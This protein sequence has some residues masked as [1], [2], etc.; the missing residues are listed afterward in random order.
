M[1]LTRSQG[2][3]AGARLQSEREFIRAVGELAQLAGWSTYHTYCSRR[4]VPGFPDLVL[5]RPGEL[6]FIELKTDLGRLTP[7]QRDWL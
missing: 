4:R 1:T 2:V 3:T 7:E 6:L 5:A